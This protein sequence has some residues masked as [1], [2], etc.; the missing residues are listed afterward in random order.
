MR[1]LL[2]RAPDQEIT[3]LTALILQKLGDPSVVP[4][5]LEVLRRRDNFF[6]LV[7]RALAEAGVKEAGPIMF[8]FITSKINTDQYDAIASTLASLRILHFDIPDALRSQWLSDPK[9]H[10]YVKFELGVRPLKWS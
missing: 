7:G 4:T 3:T 6:S 9:C 8:Q 2:S 10:P 1:D 5:L